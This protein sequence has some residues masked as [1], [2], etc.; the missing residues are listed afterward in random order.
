MGRRPIENGELM[1]YVGERVRKARLRAGLSQVDVAKEFG[2][3]QAGLSKLE[4]GENLLSLELL[5]RLP[6][7]FGV[8][9]IYFLPDEALTDEDKKEALGD[10]RLQEIVHTWPEL[11]DAARDHVLEAVRLSSGIKK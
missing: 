11:S 5:I 10:P 4:R 8:P 3:T 7:I 1:K 6:A 9:I 2:M